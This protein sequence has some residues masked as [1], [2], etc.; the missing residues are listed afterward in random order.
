M[1][2]SDLYAEY[3]LAAA[4]AEGNHCIIASVVRLFCLIGFLRHINTV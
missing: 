2:T 1:I 4:G 3:A